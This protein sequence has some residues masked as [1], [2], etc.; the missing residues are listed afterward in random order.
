MRVSL[1]RKSGAGM[2]SANATLVLTLMGDR[3]YSRESILNMICQDLGKNSRIKLK[4][5]A[6]HTRRFG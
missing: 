2:R 1:T 3:I 6:R 5:L 4:K